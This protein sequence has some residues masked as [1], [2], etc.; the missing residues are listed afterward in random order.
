MNM[1]PQISEA[2]YEV[3]KIIWSQEP[4]STTEVTN[5]LAP[6]TAWSPKTIQTLLKRLVQKGAITYEKKSRVFVYTALIEQADYLNQEN[7]H[8]LKRFYNGNITSMLANFVKEERLTGDE[9][10]E[11]KRLLSP[12]G[13]GES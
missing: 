8:F 3:M 10:E 1:L 7:D 6:T 11:L 9:L 13:K 12:D 2:E 5:Q 4:V